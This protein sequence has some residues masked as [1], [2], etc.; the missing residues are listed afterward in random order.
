[1][2]QKAEAVAVS[3]ALVA[4]NLVLRFPTDAPEVMVTAAV[5]AWNRRFS[6]HFEGDGYFGGDPE[7]E[8]FTGDDGKVVCCYAY[9]L[10]ADDRLWSQIACSRT[11]TVDEPVLDVQRAYA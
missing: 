4:R 7:I 6:N 1:M 10:H 8:M 5:E 3:G 9:Y 2:T 11:L